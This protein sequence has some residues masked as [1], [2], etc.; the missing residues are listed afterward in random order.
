MAKNP[1]FQQLEAIPY[2]Q[3]ALSNHL[4]E[5]VAYRHI[6]QLIDHLKN[7]GLNTIW[8][9]KHFKVFY[10]PTGGGGYYSWS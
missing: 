6:T 4:P 5:S 3:K 2:L 10:L 7:N 1:G 8:E 9:G